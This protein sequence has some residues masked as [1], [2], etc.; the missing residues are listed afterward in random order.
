MSVML[1]S[2]HR[3][4]NAAAPRALVEGPH[5]V[6][7]VHVGPHFGEAIDEVPQRSILLSVVVCLRPVEIAAGDDRGVGVPCTCACSRA[8]CST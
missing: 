2:I 8:E 3:P 5:E 1:T 7:K 4:S 6:P